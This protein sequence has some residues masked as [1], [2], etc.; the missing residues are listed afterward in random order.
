[1]VMPSDFLAPDTYTVNILTYYSNYNI[2]LFSLR[3]RRINT[4]LLLCSQRRFDDLTLRP[5]GINHITAFNIT[6]FGIA[7][8]VSFNTIKHRSN[9]VVR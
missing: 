7:A 5:G 3:H 9:R 2:R 6:Y 8:N 4:C 1:M